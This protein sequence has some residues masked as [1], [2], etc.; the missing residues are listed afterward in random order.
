MTEGRGWTRARST[1][2]TYYVPHTTEA[3]GFPWKPPNNLCLSLTSTEMS[4]QEMTFDSCQ[5]CSCFN[6]LTESKKSRLDSNQKI[7]QDVSS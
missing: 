4:F 6:F 7:F 3:P 2:G 5:D 1:T